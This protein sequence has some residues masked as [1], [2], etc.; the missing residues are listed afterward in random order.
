MKSSTSQSKPP[1]PTPPSGGEAIADQLSAID[2]S[3]LDRLLEMRREEGRIEEFRQRADKMKDSVDPLVWD[4][5]VDDYQKRLAAIRAQAR[6]LKV[7]ARTEYG[8][9]LALRDRIS[10]EQKTAQLSKAEIDFR[11]AVGELAEDDLADRLSA[12]VGILTR[13]E[14]ELAAVGELRTRFIEAYGEDIESAAPPAPPEPVAPTA[15]APTPPAAV[16]TPPATMA[17][18][19][20]EPP[21]ATI[22]PG[23]SPDITTLVSAEEVKSAR[24]GGNGSAP[25]PA[26][27]PS[28]DADPAATILHQPEP[29][30]PA[31]ADSDDHT[32]LLPAAALL[33][34][35]DQP[36]R[37]EYRLAAIN[38]LGRSDDNHLQIARPGV[39]RRHA[40]VMAANNGFTIRD[41]E[42]QNGVFVN[43]ERI[44][45]H[46]LKDGEHIV[47]GDS[48]ML[49]RSPWPPKG[50]GGRTKA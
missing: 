9:L 46:P 7:E 14:E 8:K 50:R 34:D 27:P 32:F 48:T 33:I 1:S 5:V 35:P 4:R 45:E 39:S 40:V 17:V 31:G 25:E 3:V 24:A 28:N 30:A 49:F 19:V 44:S 36:T 38:Y 22:P 37:Q 20:A 41:L 13:C 6:P 26:T 18:P 23:D 42:S 16:P 43:G 2:T 12:S 11:H 10:A 15:S 29:A 21:A 47:I